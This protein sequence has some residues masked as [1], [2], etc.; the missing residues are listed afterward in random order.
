MR[1]A[2]LADVH[3]NREALEA[4]LGHAES[5]GVDRFIFLGDYVNYGADPEWTVAEIRRRVERGAVAL[6]GNHDASAGG[7]PLAMTP[8][9]EFSL[10][11]T[12][13]R[14][15]IEDRRFLAALPLVLDEHG[16][17][18]SH[19][20]GSAPEKWIYVR[21][22]QDAYR[23]LENVGRSFAVCGHVHRPA[24]YSVSPAEKT[25]A[26]TPVDGVPVP[27]LPRRR[28]LAVVGSVGQPRDGNPAAAYAL[29][30]LGRAEITMWRVPYDVD[31]AAAR[32]RSAGLPEILAER[33][34]AGW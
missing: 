11:W 22:K 16:I 21:D 10:D 34:R 29:L 5:R 3:A 18:F 24:L 2:L 14:L 25:T 1:I 23:S 30:D 31:R 4:C 8:A 15:G 20:E 27:L 7:A 13:N 26:F 17:L 33:L 12:R 32:I 28:W 6:L 9:A 19:A